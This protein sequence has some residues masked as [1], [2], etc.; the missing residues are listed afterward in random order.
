MRKGEGLT[1]TGKKSVLTIWDKIKLGMTPK[2]LN[3]KFK[4]IRVNNILEKGYE[5]SDSE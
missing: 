4:R 5:L 3:N 2:N 1:S